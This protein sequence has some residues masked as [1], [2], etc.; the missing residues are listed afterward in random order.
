MTLG[1]K[2]TKYRSLSMTTHLIE[3]ILHEYTDPYLQ[4]TWKETKA[5]KQITLSDQKLSIDI[6]LGYPVLALEKKV[7]DPLKKKLLATEGIQ[8]VAINLTAKIE[9]HITQPNVQPIPNV[10]N[11]IAVGSGKGGVGKSTTALNL[12]LALLTQGAKVGMLDADI[13]GPN[14]P[15]MLGAHLRIKPENGKPL[16]PVLVQGLQSMSMAY[17][18]EA[19]IPMIWRGPMV[20]SALLQLARDTAWENLDY[21]IVDLPPGT[22]DI[23]LTLS[24]KI[25]VSGA[26]IVTTPQDV[27]LLDARKGFEMFRKV[28]VPV[29]GLIENMSMHICSA[30]GHQE[31]IFGEGGAKR[32]AEEIDMELLGQLPLAKSIR[33]QA[34]AGKP[35][36]IAEPDSEIA[37]LYHEI[38]RRIAA[39][40]SLQPKNY[41]AKFPKINVSNK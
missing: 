30:C 35:I 15:Q 36:V 4:K 25:P 17:L 40:L 26:V 7:L 19:Q 11:I 23:Q 6:T 39:K 28:N 13:Y 33:E 21:L 22:G 34:D 16:P 38:A 27:A 14:Q 31:A 41:A 3:T 8:E 2:P 12:A 9:P 1:E 37:G 24:Q 20:S 10:K 29:L 5:I 32:L 18:I